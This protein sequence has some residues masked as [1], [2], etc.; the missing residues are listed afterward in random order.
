MTQ[1]EKRI[2]HLSSRMLHV[3][4]ERTSKYYLRT[5]HQP[6][7]LIHSS[8]TRLENNDKW[9]GWWFSYRA[10]MSIDMHNDMPG[11]YVYTMKFRNVLLA[12]TRR[13]RALADLLSGHKAR[14]SQSAR[15]FSSHKAV[16]Y[17]QF[18]IARKFALHRPIYDA[19][20]K[21]TPRAIE[22]SKVTSFLDENEMSKSPGRSRENSF[23]GSLSLS[24][25]HSLSL[26]LLSRG[27]GIQIWIYAVRE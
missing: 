21:T 10:R 27:R 3:C 11:L 26:F 1:R 23:P 25:F 18:S 20:W 17:P 13:K 6:R 22:S 2:I 5:M 12:G 7:L 8:N 15:Y 16:R 24:L 9:R 4:R 19:P 14:C